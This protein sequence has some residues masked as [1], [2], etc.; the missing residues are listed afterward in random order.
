MASRGSLGGLAR[1][2]HD[3]LKVFDA[4]G[5]EIILIETVGVGQ[6][7]VEIA[8]TA[9][10][11]VVVEAPGLGD[12]IQAIKAGIL[13]IADIFAVNKADRPGADKTA[14]AL[15]S[16]L[17]LGHPLDHRFMHH[18]SFITVDSPSL[19][20]EEASGPTWQIPIIQTMALKGQGIDRLMTAIAEHHQHLT[21]TG[22]LAGR[23][24]ARLADELETR[25]Q[26]ELLKRLL[27]QIP[28]D[29]L[30]E[31]ITKLVNRTLSPY[32]AVQTILEDY[33]F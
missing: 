33:S 15:K 6:G 21:Q 30:S 10:T 22:E 5:F 7:E 8:R 29:D 24:R 26:T 20:V 17:E 4:A 13:E 23:N 1:G 32:N 16:M 11:I 3:A 14:A 27:N 2:V 12:D 19:E 18:G 9:H 25:L 28:S 31:I